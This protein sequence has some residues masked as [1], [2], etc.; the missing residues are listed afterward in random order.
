MHEA[1]LVIQIVLVPV[2]VTA[3]LGL[4]NPPWSWTGTV[5]EPYLASLWALVWVPCCAV[6]MT[7]RPK[8]ILQ[9]SPE[10]QGMYMH[11]ALL[12]INCL[13]LT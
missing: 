11:F 4:H 5:G 3:M 1:P 12:H 6:G 7:R 9:D 13:T 8:S 2:G 10:V